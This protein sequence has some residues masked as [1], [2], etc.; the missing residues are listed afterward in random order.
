[1]A[2]K[3]RVFLD[4]SALIAGLLSPYGAAGEIILL[5]RAKEVELVISEYV[6][7]EIKRSSFYRSHVFALRLTNLLFTDLKVLPYP[8]RSSVKSAAKVISE[9]DAP[10]LAS[11]KQAKVNTLVTWDK[12]F[13][14]KKVE[15][16]LGSPIYLPG[17]FLKQYRKTLSP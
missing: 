17:D 14:S 11:A 10:I 2:V 7:E 1:M 8:S 16:F 3:P 4:T 6:L 15:S 12:E 5:H 13:L 9:K